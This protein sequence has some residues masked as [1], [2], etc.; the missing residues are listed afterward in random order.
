MTV[1]EKLILGVIDPV[2]DFIMRRVLG[3]LQE[4]KTTTTTAVATT[5][6]GCDVFL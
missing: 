4:V 2:Q 5:A 1:I 3:E 6:P